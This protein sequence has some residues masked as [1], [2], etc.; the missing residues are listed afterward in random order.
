MDI[1]SLQNYF[2]HLLG[3]AYTRLARRSFA[4]FGQGSHMFYPCRINQPGRI[5]IGSKTVLFSDVWLN[6]VIEWGGESYNGEI[7]I[8]DC[9]HILNNAQITAASSMRIGNHVSIGRNVII[10][11]HIH[12]YRDVSRPILDAP[13][14]NIKPVAIG[15]ETVVMANTV[16]APGSSIGRHCFIGANSL[17]R[18]EI[19]DYSLAVGSPAKVITR[20]D[21]ATGRWERSGARD[22][23][24]ANL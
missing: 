5:Y 2:Q 13:L 9:C 3:R 23:N 6:P 21:L 1:F 15:D 10:A 24:P 20:Y 11:D 18:S 19:P 4:A 12:D 7:V 22:G 16:I 14:G 17:V 8:G